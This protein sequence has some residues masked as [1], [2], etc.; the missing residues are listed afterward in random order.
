MRIISWNCCCQKGGFTE[1]KRDKI[2]K[3]NPDVL[4]VQECKQDDWLKLNYTSEKGHWYG[5]GKESQGD[6]NKSLGIGIFC[7]NEYSIDC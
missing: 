7:N 4:I 2:L 3:L 1:E 5:D 6:P